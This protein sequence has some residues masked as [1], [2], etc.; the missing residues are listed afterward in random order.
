MFLCALDYA[1]V[2]FLEETLHYNSYWILFGLM[3]FNGF[4]QS[5]TWPNLLMTIQAYFDPKKQST[6]L[7]FWSTNSNVGNIVGYFLCY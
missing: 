1:L 5:Y 4:L 2:P 6:L 7:A 3:A